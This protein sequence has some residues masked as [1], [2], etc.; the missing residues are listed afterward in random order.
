MEQAVPGTEQD[1]VPVR[2]PERVTAVAGQEASAGAE[3]G[4]CKGND[5]IR[6]AP[7]TGQRISG[8]GHEGVAQGEEVRGVRQLGLRVVRRR[9]EVAIFIDNVDLD[10]AERE[11]SATRGGQQSTEPMTA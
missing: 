6:V 1:Q 11:R 7:D 5:L 10:A 2:V 9:S 8:R 3:R 4:G